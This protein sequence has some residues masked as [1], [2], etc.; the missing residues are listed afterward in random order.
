MK[1][2]PV[3]LVFFAFFS[4]LG[5]QAQIEEQK[6]A[7]IQAE[8]QQNNL[9]KQPKKQ[10]KKREEQSSENVSLPK[11]HSIAVAQARL[12]TSLA[13]GTVILEPGPCEPPSM[14]FKYN[15]RPIF[16][17]SNP[18]YKLPTTNPD[19]PEFI[20]Y[21]ST[22]QDPMATGLNP[23][24]TD[25]A[26]QNQWN[27]NY[28]LMLEHYGKSNVEK[29][30]QSDW[31]E[32]LTIMDSINEAS[33][34]LTN[35]QEAQSKKTKYVQEAQS[36]IVLNDKIQINLNTQGMQESKTGQVFQAY[37]SPTIKNN[38]IRVFYKNAANVNITIMDMEGNVVH[39]ETTDDANMYVKKYD[40]ST[41]SK[42]KYILILKSGERTIEQ[43]YS[44]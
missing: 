11:G 30:D 7:S 4:L 8:E 12:R 43:T 2:I 5:V 21:L 19:A 42:G 31:K 23:L 15:N 37:I 10:K 6:D 40:V 39:Q 24:G 14:G 17:L 29:I 25:F 1:K 16:M 9:E 18:F 3:L 32:Y 20:A 27:G 35:L 26:F 36:K 38:T 34:H 33:V 22:F 41:L 28:E 13:K 44:I